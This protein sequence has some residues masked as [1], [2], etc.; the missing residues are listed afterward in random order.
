MIYDI[1]AFIGL[2]LMVLLLLGVNALGVLMV[3]LQLPGTWLML[4][5]TALFAWWRWDDGGFA[6][7]GGWVLLTLLGMA[8]I[9]EIVEF[10]QKV[11]E[12]HDH[13]R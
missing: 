4:A 3:A 1:L 2:L 9:G 13:C 5:A 8:I 10:L 6:A 7:I 12:R 11:G